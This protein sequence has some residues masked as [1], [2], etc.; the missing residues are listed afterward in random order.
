MAK[1]AGA[2][3]LIDSKIFISVFCTLLDNFIEFS[4]A[5]EFF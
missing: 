1:G 3:T 2:Q 4:V 5:R